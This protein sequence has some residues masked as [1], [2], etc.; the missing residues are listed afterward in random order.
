[1]FAEKDYTYTKLE[2]L[3]NFQHLLSFATV[4]PKLLNIILYLL[5]IQASSEIGL[6]NKV[7]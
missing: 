1:M 5:R 4:R 3:E 6:G 2:L 7:L